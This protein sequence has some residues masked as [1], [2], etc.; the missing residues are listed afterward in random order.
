MKQERKVWYAPNKFESY[1]EEEIKAVEACLRDGWLAGFGPRSIEFE[2]KIAKRFGKKYGVFVNSGSS[3]CLLAIAALD[4]PKGCKI[5]TPACTFSTTLAPIIQLGYKPVFCDVD[6]T[7]YVPTVE[8]IIALIDAEVKAIMVP[9]LIGNKPDWKTLR[10]ELKHIGREDIIVIE[11]SADTI[12][13]TEETDVAT[14]SFYAS[15]VITAGGTGGMVMF[16]DKKHVDRALQYRDWGRMGDNSEI[17][18]DRFNHS[19]DG[20]PYDH[21]FLYDVL[22]YNFKCSEMSAAFGLVQLK[23]FE[24]FENIR[25]ANI[26]R[27]LENLKDVTEII[28][29]DDSIKPNWLAIPLQTERRL[30]LLTFLENNNIQTRVTFAGNVTRHPIYREYLQP[31]DNSDAIMKN[32]FLLGAHHGMTI[33]DVDYV[34]DKIKEFFKK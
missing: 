32:G 1:G 14:T 18:D 24:T 16:N 29:P 28:L 5:I 27:Y 6:L 15:H 9:N 23:R 31:F 8:D 33:K 2:E 10:S 25:R 17:M 12:T 11:D 34:C 20:I 13:Y 22:G 26:E 21:K 3:A 7:S 30:E 19:V 4:L